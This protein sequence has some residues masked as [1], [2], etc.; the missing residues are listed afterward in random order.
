MI[1]FMRENQL[2][3]LQQEY[4]KIDFKIEAT[5]RKNIVVSVIKK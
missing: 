5:Y 3:E 1:I 4:P 2:S